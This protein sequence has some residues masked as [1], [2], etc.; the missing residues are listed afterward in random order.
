MAVAAATAAAEQDLHS[1][2]PAG[3]AAVA[4]A[5]PQLRLR[6]V[7][8]VP[9]V[10]AE[11]AVALLLAAVEGAAATNA[12]QQMRRLSA[13]EAEGVQHCQQLSAAVQAAAGAAATGDRRHPVSRRRQSAQLALPAKLE[14]AAA[15]VAEAAA[16][17]AVAAG[18]DGAAQGWGC[19]FPSRDAQ[20]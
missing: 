20:Q 18:A 2:Q 8:P 1:I 4:V 19:G 15:A 13:E 11:A 7:V 5:A 16:A 9:V 3:V 14:G 17:V 12:P 6:H 10:G